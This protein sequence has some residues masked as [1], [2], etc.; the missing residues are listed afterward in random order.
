MHR[1][2]A[3]RGLLHP[4]AQCE[5]PS[6]HDVRGSVVEE[7]QFGVN[8]DAMNVKALRDLI[9][10]LPDDTEVIVDG[11]HCLWRAEAKK[12]FAQPYNLN[13]QTQAGFEPSSNYTIPVIIIARD[14]HR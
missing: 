2:R 7:E 4:A 8:K 13:G 6:H 11:S 5:D 3:R 1:H 9:A 12:G 14:V 10:E